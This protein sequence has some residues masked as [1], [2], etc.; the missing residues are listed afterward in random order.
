ML[1]KFR[2]RTGMVGLKTLNNRRSRIRYALG[3]P[4]EGLRIWAGQD[5][6]LNSFTVGNFAGCLDDQRINDVV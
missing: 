5:R 4:G 3:M 6:P 2:A 1:F